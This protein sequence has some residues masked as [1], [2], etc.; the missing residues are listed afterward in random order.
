MAEGYILV[1]D[2]DE[3]TCRLLRHAIERLGYNVRTVNNG[4]SA[5]NMLESQRPIAAI[6]DIVM[7]DMNG[8][9]LFK[10]IRSLPD[11]EGMPIIISTGKECMKEYFE[12]DGDKAVPDAFL[13]KPYSKNDLELAL[14]KIL[15]R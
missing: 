6:L 10:K 11:M 2:D 3:N 4:T 12:L 1:V 7:P 9:V 13:T 8:Y 14:N 5:L 15:K